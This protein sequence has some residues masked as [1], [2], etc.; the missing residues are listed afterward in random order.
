MNYS[1]RNKAVLGLIAGF[2]LIVALLVIVSLSLEISKESLTGAYWKAE[3]VHYEYRRDVLSIPWLSRFRSPVVYEGWVYWKSDSY[4]GD[5]YSEPAYVPVS[6]NRSMP[7]RPR[8]G[9]LYCEFKPVVYNF[10]FG[11]GFAGHTIE[12]PQE[13]WNKHIAGDTFVVTRAFGRIIAI[14]PVE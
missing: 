4:I 13:Q 6:C 5:K 12:V 14:E 9:D 1:T 8:Y 11:P 3:I 10:A 2:V 7:S